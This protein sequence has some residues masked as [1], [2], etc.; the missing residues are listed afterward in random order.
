MNIDRLI[1][2]QATLVEAQHRPTPVILAS[3]DAESKL[4]IERDARR[5][6]LHRQ[7]RYQTSHSHWVSL[8]SVIPKCSRSAA[9]Y[10]RSSA[11]SRSCRSSSF[12][13]ISL[14]PLIVTRP[15][16]VASEQ[17]RRCV[18]CDSGEV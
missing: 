13:R 4:L 1:H 2:H 10:S 14:F 12:V 15:S 7:H 18:K 3:L 9:A 17:T 8:C 16:R 11:S 5:H 6:A